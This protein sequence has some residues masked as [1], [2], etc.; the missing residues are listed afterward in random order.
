M[1]MPIISFRYWN[2][3]HGEN[4]EEVRRDLEGMQTMRIL[5]RNMAFFLH[6]KDIGMKMGL[7]FPRPEETTFTNFIPKTAI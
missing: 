7:Q 1:Q 2:I 6:C 4:P 5:G 3:V